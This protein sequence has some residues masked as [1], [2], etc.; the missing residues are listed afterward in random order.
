MNENINKNGLSLVYDLPKDVHE[1]MNR[2]IFH[3]INSMNVNFEPTNTFE[4]EIGGI[5]VKFIKK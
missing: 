2:D 1:M 4:V 3:R 5:L